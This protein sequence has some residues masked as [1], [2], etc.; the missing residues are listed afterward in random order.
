MSHNFFVIS[1]FLD[2]RCASQYWKIPN[3]PPPD[4]DVLISRC[5]WPR[6]IPTT[7]RSVFFYRAVLCTLLLNVV[8][9]SILDFVDQ[10]RKRKKR[11]MLQ[12]IFNCFSVKKTMGL[13]LSGSKSRRISQF[14]KWRVFQ[15]LSVLYVHILSCPHGN[16]APFLSGKVESP[17]EFY[18]GSKIYHFYSI[19]TWAS[20]L[21]KLDR[22]VVYEYMAFWG[23][24][25]FLGES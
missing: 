3:Y 24:F 4:G 8:I 16:G 19:D 22:T 2:K 17:A 7:N 9:G 6:W 15:C 13:L 1:L 5:E 11:R 10:E 25:S 12:R 21:W 20:V 23:F 18:C 14:E